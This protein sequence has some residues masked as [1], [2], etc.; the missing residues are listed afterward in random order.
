M[1]Q[2]AP[3]CSSLIKLFSFPEVTYQ[4]QLPRCLN[5]LNKECVEHFDE[6]SCSAAN[7]MCE[8]EIEA[9][10]WQSGLNPYDISQNCDGGMEVLC[11]PITK[12]VIYPL[13]G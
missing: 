9:P 11:Y 12:S 5:M 6:I 3:G 7:E 1:R 4:V 10:F 2:N 8:N 13:S